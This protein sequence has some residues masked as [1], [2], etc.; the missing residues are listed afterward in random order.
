MKIKIIY[1]YCIVILLNTDTKE[2]SIPSSKN[3]ERNKDLMVSIIDLAL[4]KI[5]GAAFDQVRDRLYTK[6][7]CFVTDCYEHPEYLK[8]VLMEI[9]GDCSKVVI[10]SI[11]NDFRKISPDPGIEPF[12]KIM[13]Q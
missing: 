1:Q 4:V 5:G 3:H 11:K 6:Y 8:D 13:Y 9:F 2:V 7:H 10:E 12:L